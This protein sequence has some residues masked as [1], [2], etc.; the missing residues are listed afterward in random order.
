MPW[1]KVP[2]ALDD[3]DVIFLSSCAN[4]YIG[5]NATHLWQYADNVKNLCHCRQV[6]TG[7]KTGF[8]A[9]F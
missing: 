1:F 8:L 5:D 7:P 9:K 3:N 4:S 6:R 2:F